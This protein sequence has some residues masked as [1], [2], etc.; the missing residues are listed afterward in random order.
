MLLIGQKQW[1]LDKTLI[2]TA[3]LILTLVI[4]YKTTELSNDIHLILKKN[5]KTDTWYLIKKKS[6]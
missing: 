5:T 6:V 1:F 3:K 4:H 2:V